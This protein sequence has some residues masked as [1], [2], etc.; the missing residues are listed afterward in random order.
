MY[1][2]NIDTAQQFI[3]NKLDEA[4][5]KSLLHWAQ[6]N[7]LADRGYDVCFTK[8]L[9]EYKNSVCPSNPLISIETSTKNEIENKCKMTLSDALWDLCRKNILRPGVSHQNNTFSPVLTVND[10][11]AVTAYG[12]NWLSKFSTSDLLPADPHQ[13][14]S[15]F[16]QH[17]TL[18]G[19]NYYKRAKEAVNCYLSG[20][21]LACCVMCGAATESILLSAAFI[22]KDRD[23]VLSEYKCSGGRRK[24]ENVL[25]GKARKEIKDIY[26]KYTDII[27]YWRDETSHGH[28]TDVDC[29]EA[30]ISMLTLLRFAVFIKE[31]WDE[32]TSCSTELARI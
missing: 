28:D 25:F 29:D 13:L 19:Y 2:I 24:I 12:K 8:A 18:Y 32:V 26:S 23:S 1:E 6:P 16:E 20:N 31:H 27:S 22:K 4:N 15:V 30:F 3:I 14:S 9:A 5:K 21:Y 11:Y 17:Q 10:G 7:S